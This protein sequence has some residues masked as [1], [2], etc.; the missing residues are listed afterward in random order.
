MVCLRWRPTT[1]ATWNFEYF[2]SRD[3]GFERLL[4]MLRRGFEATLD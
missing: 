2:A 4:E 1:S 3:A